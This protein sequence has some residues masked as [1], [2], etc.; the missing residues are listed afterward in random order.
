M[1]KVKPKDLFAADI[2]VELG[3]TWIPTS[4]IKQFLCDTLAIQHSHHLNVNFAPITGAWEIEGKKYNFGPKS[5]I[6]FGVENYMNALVLAENALNGRQSKIYKTVYVDGKET[7][8]IDNEKTIVAQQK[9]EL[10]KQAFQNWIFN[11]EERKNRLVAY[12][13][14]HFNNIKPRE[15]DGSHLTFPGMSS[16]IKLREHQKNAIAHTLY[17]SNTLFAHCVGAGKTFEMAASAMEA[18]RLGLCSKSMIV[19]PKHLTEQFGT[20]FLQLYP[21]AKIFSKKIILLT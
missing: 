10:I 1:E 15:F 20:E 6:T 8:Q 19:V 5:E 9:T 14:R 12:Y 7:K 13:N 17:G 2:H 4:D 21:N 16:K 18:K 3:A 11:D